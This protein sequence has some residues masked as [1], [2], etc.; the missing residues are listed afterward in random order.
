MI[1]H[2]VSNHGYARIIGHPGKY[3]LLPAEKNGYEFF[4]FYRASYITKGLHSHEVFLN[5][6]EPIVA[7]VI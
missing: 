6:S 2:Y 1:L 3:T 5:R 4:V 7:G